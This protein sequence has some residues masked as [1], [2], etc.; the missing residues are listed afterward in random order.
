MSLSSV[1][2]CCVLTSLPP[3]SQF[4]DGEQRRVSLR[5]RLPFLMTTLTLHL[6][7][8]TDSS[9][10]LR[11][12]LFSTS[13]QPHLPRTTSRLRGPGRVGPFRLREPL[14]RRRILSTDCHRGKSASL[15]YVALQTC[16]ETATTDRPN[17]QFWIVRRST[18][19]STDSTHSCPCSR[20]LVS[21]RA[22]RAWRWMREGGLGSTWFPGWAVDSSRRTSPPLVSL[23]VPSTLQDYTHTTNTNVFTVASSSC[24]SCS[25]S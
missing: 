22:S 4:R 14:T 18:S 19:T 10:T 16:F 12:R 8:Q 2:Q 21:G 17:L 20:R 25:V 23:Y 7:N 13:Y 9:P 1:A 11:T 5:P 15:W 24:P 3:E 6:A